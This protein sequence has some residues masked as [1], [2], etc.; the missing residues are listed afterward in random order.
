MKRFRSAPRSRAGCAK[1][2]TTWPIASSPGEILLEID[3]TD[4]QLNVRQAQR[5]LQVELA[6]LGLNGCPT[7]KVD[8]THIPT[9]VQAQ[10][11][12]DNAQ[13]RHGTRQDPLERKASAEEELTEKMSEFRVAQAEYDNQVLVAKAG[14]AA[15]QVKQE[16]LA[17]AKQQLQDTDRARSRAQPAGPRS[18]ERL[19]LCDHLPARWPKAAMS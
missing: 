10:L 4:Y 16:A 15:I 5:A 9:V 14:I 19:E 12:R 11:R 7:A 6:K 1:S 8:V 17:I 18:G 2:P 13:K 3:P